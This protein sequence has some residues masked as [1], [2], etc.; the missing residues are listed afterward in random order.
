MTC[1]PRVS[2]HIL[3]AWLQGDF[4]FYGDQ[5]FTC[6]TSLE[7]SVLMWYIISSN[8][9]DASHV[10]GESGW[11]M[12]RT[13]MHWKH[14]TYWNIPCIHALPTIVNTNTYTDQINGPGEFTCGFLEKVFMNLDST[15]KFNLSKGRYVKDKVKWANTD[16]LTMH[17]YELC[18]RYSWYKFMDCSTSPHWTVKP[19]NVAPPSLDSGSIC[20]LWPA[21]LCTKVSA[22]EHA[23]KSAPWLQL[24]S[25]W[26]FV[27]F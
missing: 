25:E 8:L 13:S 26:W 14:E 1:R 18:S 7:V 11:H 12:Q 20:T 22:K 6:I 27:S 23:E 2:W 5:Y 19:D 3:H 17:V 15:C 10:P 4:N 21:R 24:L 9:F 16:T